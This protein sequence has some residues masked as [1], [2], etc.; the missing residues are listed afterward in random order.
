MIEAVAGVGAV[1]HAA[2]VVVL[3][4][5][6]LAM[7][8]DNAGNVATMTEPVSSRPDKPKSTGRKRRS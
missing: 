6:Y 4:P 3:D 1:E 5:C 2:E 7:P 8:G